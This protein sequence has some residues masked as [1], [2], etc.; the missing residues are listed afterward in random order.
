MQK[1]RITLLGST[2]S[3]G[4]QTLCVIDDHPGE[5]E[6]VGLAA[7]SSLD[8]IE[9]YDR[10]H[11]KVLVVFD[12]K[13]AEKVA[14]ERPSAKVLCGKEGLLA[15]AN[16]PTDLM[17]AAMSG[18]HSLL[19]VAT[20]IQ[21]KVPVALANK[22]LLV[23]AGEWI[24]KEV[25][26]QGTQLLPLDSEHTAI[27]QLLQ[28][29][30]PK[31]LKNIY[32][33]ASGGPFKEFTHEELKN[34]TVEQA[35]KHPTWKM[36]SKIT[37]DSSTL[38]NKGLEVIEAK[39]LFDLKPEQ[40]HVVVHPQSIIHGI[41][42]W[43]D[44]SF[45]VQASLPS[46]KS[47]IAYCLQFPHR[48]PSFEQSLDFKQVMQWD[49]SPPDINRFKCLGLAYDALKIGKSMPCFMNAVNE[50]CVSLFLQKRISWAQIGNII[51]ELMQRYQPQELSSIED[52][53]REDAFARQH[54]REYIK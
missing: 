44:H 36:G 9:Q 5:F 29:K 20:A 8:I 15:L 43:V 52:V 34:V 4:K 18:T 22:E 13:A 1:R 24:A 40:I 47:P 10:Y 41:V 39:W 17:V 45:H 31:S 23:A 25:K 7:H 46:M 38:M 37:I 19:P 53:L 28:G 21:N 26:K 6:I 51:E 30:D 54:L 27:F 48:K 42:E 14:L 35:L 32:L 12:P 33:T 16:E 3:I 11:P 49:L 2:G 50:E